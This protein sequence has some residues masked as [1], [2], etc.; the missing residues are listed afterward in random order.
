MDLAAALRARIEDGTATVAVLGQGYVG[1][2]LAMRAVELGFGV[3]GYEVSDARVAAL[4]DGTS[5]GEDVPSAV[6]AD[7]LAKDYRPTND[8]D[9]LVGVDVAV[10][11][12]PTPLREGAPDLSFVESAAE[13]LAGRIRPGALVV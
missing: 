12:V 11:T 3:V 1:L 9:D 6:V 8:P 2:P 4:R 10:I 7:A 13:V 5:Y